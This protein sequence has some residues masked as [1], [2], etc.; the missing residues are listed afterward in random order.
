MRNEGKRESVG[1]RPLFKVAGLGLLVVLLVALLASSVEAWPWSASWARTTTT[2]AST[3]AAVATTAVPAGATLYEETDKSLIYAG[4]WRSSEARGYSGRGAAYAFRSGASMTTKFTGSSLTWLAPTSSSCGIARVTLDGGTASLVDLY[5]PRTLYQQP[6]YSTGELG[7]GSHTLTI[8]WTGLKNP[9]SRNTR[10]YLDAL[11]VV[12]AAAGVPAGAAATTIT[13]IPATTTTTAPATTPTTLP[14]M[15]IP[16]LP[17]TTLITVLAP[18]NTGLDP[19]PEATTTTTVVRTTTTT[20]V[21]AT[22]AAPPTTTTTARP[23]TT[24]TRP[25]TTSTT[26]ARPSTT[27]T[28]TVKA[29]GRTIEAMTYC[30]G[31]GLRNDTGNIAAALAAC[32]PGDTLHF[33]AGTYLGDMTCVEGVHISGDGATSWIKGQVTAASHMDFTDIKMGVT[34]HFFGVAVNSDTHDFNCYRCTFTGGAEGVGGVIHFYGAVIHDILFSDCTIEKPA[35]VCNGVTIHT[36]SKVARQVYNIEFRNCHFMGSPRMNFEICSWSNEAAAT[37]PFR[38]V[39][40]IGCTFEASDSTS[41]SYAANQM[42]DGTWQSGNSTISNCWIKDFAVN[43][44]GETGKHGIEL[45][46]AV[47]M[48]VVGNRIEGSHGHV[49]LLMGT[50]IYPFKEWHQTGG[51]W[52]CNNVI[53]KNVFDGR[54]SAHS[55]V[56]LGG[57]NFVFRGNTVYNRGRDCAVYNA[58]E[59]RFENNTIGVYAADGTLS[60]DCPA[61]T[62]RDADDITFTGNTFKSR[63]PFTVGLTTDGTSPTRPATNIIFTD[64]IFEKDAADTAIR[65]DSASSFTEI[66]STYLTAP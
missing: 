9:S 63:Y 64:N 4:S 65:K 47:N 62:I 24:T 61:L 32:R 15:T 26:A 35:V 53:E 46:G 57:S 42:H 38:N 10:V 29:T 39:N 51:L 66:G 60:T 19:T 48:T 36:Y 12:E 8:E 3:S 2:T 7:S 21:R 40:L 28:T 1:T 6:V 33:A 52:R 56:S 58:S 44:S 5:S 45:A 17:H 30:Y 31:D 59:S 43:D 49:M 50:T 22:T 41:I 18:I 54:N 14:V 27:T 16:T 20:T 23:I 13:T 55:S 25:P 11:S 34:G 37:Y